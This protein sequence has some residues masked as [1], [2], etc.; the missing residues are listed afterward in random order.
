MR[1]DPSWRS[2]PAPPANADAFIKAADY[3]TLPPDT[4]LSCGTVYVGDLN[5]LMTS[6]LTDIV[7]GKVAPATGLRA[8]ATQVNSCMAAA[9][10]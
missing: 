1:N 6:T 2:L 4:P 7:N 9:T 8:A 5:V 3:G 10:K